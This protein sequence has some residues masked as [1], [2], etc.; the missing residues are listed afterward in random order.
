MNRAIAYAARMVLRA[1]ENK[2]SAEEEIQGAM[3]VREAAAVWND[4][5]REHLGRWAERFGIRLMDFHIGH[6]RTYQA[7]RAREVE[8]SVVNEETRALLALLK[9]IDLGSDIAALHQPLRE[10]DLTPYEINAL[11]ERAQAYIQRL[12]QELAGLQTE[13]DRTTRQLRRSTWG[14]N[15]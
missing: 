5:Q 8:A 13:L 3:T 1:K 10:S 14:R 11:P 9:E 7:D 4:P 6:L 12:K 15:R 2:V